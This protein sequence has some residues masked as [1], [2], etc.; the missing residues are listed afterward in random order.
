M[1][2]RLLKSILTL[3]LISLLLTNQADARHCDRCEKIEAERAEEKE[4][5]PK[6]WLYYDN[7]ISLQTN[8]DRVSKSDSNLSPAKTETSNPHSNDPNDAPKE[9]FFEEQEVLKSDALLKLSQKVKGVPETPQEDQAGYFGGKQSVPSTAPSSYSALNTMLRTKDFL[10][11]LD[12]SFTIFVPTNDALSLLPPGTLVE[13]IQPENQ[14][15]LATFVSQHVVA[16]KLLRKDFETHR[17]Q[18][19]KSIGGRNLTLSSKNGTLTVDNAN[20]L[21][22]EP[23]GYDG[24]IYIIDKCLIP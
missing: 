19:I 6:P 15:K 17:D 20:V 13:L 2:Q 8:E 21:S 3:A 4:K 23:D 11:T 5:H 14:E 10:E 1:K 16:R 22:V 24:V 9:N 18:E 12:G 7:Q